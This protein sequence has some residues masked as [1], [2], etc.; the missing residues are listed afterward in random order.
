MSGGQTFVPLA[1]NDKT[2]ENRLT[3]TTHY[4]SLLKHFAVRFCVAVTLGVILLA[5]VELYS[6]ERYLNYGRNDAMDPAVKLDLAENGSAADREYWKEFDQ[7]NKVVYQQYV[8]WRR[9]PYQGELISINPDGVRR[10]LHTQCDDRSEAIWMFGDSVMWGVGSPDA[11]TIPSFIAQDYE[12]AG[13]PVCIL[14]YAEKGWSNTQEVIGLIELLKHATRKPDIVFFYDG[15]TEAFAAYQSGEADVHSN[16]KS[17][18]NFLDNWA[19]THAAGFSY[20]RETNTYR[21]LDK[22]AAKAPF[23]RKPVE[24]PKAR[25]DTE[26][27]AGAVVA[28]YGQNMDIVE[29]LGKQYGF[30]AIFAWYPNLAVGHKQLTPYEQ[31][32]LRYTDQDF[33]DLRLVYQEVY[34]RGSKIERPN[35]YNLADIVD[36]QRSSLYLGISHMEPAGNQIVAGRLFD[37]L[38]GKG[39]TPGSAPGAISSSHRN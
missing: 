8:L 20:F 17:F 11:E 36:D 37:I 31:Q 14:N 3:S 13:K 29:L 16:F 21:L 4:Y 15:G 19:A 39:P 6:Y 1:K 32:V 26:M 10:T 23:H 9:A 27:L 38:E 18:K 34:N 22:I 25:L 7:S 5:G 30:R 12:K 35:F 33:P 2:V 24:E 28:N